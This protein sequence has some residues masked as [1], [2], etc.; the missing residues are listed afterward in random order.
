MQTL[1]QL[2]WVSYRFG[3]KHIPRLQLLGTPVEGSEL[4]CLKHVNKKNN[5]T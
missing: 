5:P 1:S 2:M 3:N 4:T